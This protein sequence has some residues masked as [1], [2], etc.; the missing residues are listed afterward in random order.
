LS[1]LRSML[2]RQC[3]IPLIDIVQLRDDHVESPNAALEKPKTT[4]T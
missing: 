3:R 1:T 4:I 2:T